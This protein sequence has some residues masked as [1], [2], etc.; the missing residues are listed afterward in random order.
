MPNAMN[1]RPIPT[2]IAVVAALRIL[3]GGAEVVTGFRHTFFGLVTSEGFFS[4]V[5]VAAIGA[6]YVT[7]GVLVLSMRRWA[8]RL[9]VAFLVLDII[10][11]ISLVLTHAFPVDSSM[12]RFSIV[13]GTLIVAIFAAFVVWKRKEFT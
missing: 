13:G 4:T 10:G 2:S 6:L 8:S 5:V 11:R 9:A 7:A 3:F 12:Q 1:R